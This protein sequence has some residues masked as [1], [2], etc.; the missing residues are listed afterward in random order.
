MLRKTFMSLLLTLS[1]N[2]VFAM[3]CD[4]I[5]GQ[6]KENMTISSQTCEKG[7]EKIQGFMDE[8]MES[9]V[10]QMLLVVVWI[11]SK[12]NQRL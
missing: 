7:S 11:S 10:L 5:D 6:S 8:E 12:W 1:K 2:Q 3:T 4:C 9:E